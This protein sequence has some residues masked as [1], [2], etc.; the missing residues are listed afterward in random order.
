MRAV[1]QW[2]IQRIHF[3]VR[4]NVRAGPARLDG[5]L[6]CKQNIEIAGIVQ[7]PDQRQKSKSHQVAPANAICDKE[8]EFARVE[9]AALAE[10]QSFHFISIISDEDQGR[11]ARKLLSIHAQVNAKERV[12]LQNRKEGLNESYPLLGAGL[13]LLLFAEAHDVRINAQTGIVNEKAAIDFSDVH[14]N[15]A[16][17]DESAGGVF[18]ILWNVQILREMIQSAKRKNTEGDGSS[19]EFVGHGIY[20]AVSTAG[21]DNGA[22]FFHGLAS[23]RGEFR[24]TGGQMDARGRASFSKYAGE[25]FA[26]F[27][28]RTAA[29][30]AIENAG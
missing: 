15:G 2:S 17:G 5:D 8:A 7:A 4:G 13:L 26:E 11:L 20:G 12:V 29:R 28:T 21:H 24:A 30:S 25:P 22:V 23:Q 1:M 10:L 16:A 19:H 3:A 18:E 6:I 27:G 14:G 9:P